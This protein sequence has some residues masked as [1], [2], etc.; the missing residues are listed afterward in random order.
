MN[1][2]GFHRVR[3]KSRA[4]RGQKSAPWIDALHLELKEEFDRLHRLGEQLSLA[5]LKAIGTDILWKYISRQYSANILDPLSEK[6]LYLKIDHSWIQAFASRFRIVSRTHT[7][8]HSVR[9]KKE[10]QVEV[11]VASHLGKVCGLICSYP[12]D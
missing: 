8:K 2:N 3:F 5:R 11:R 1:N 10:K 9:L 4:G 12:T 6:N 7:G